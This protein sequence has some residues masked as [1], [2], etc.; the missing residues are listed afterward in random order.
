MQDCTKLD[1]ITVVGT[2]TDEHGQ[3][4]KRYLK[5][6]TAFLYTKE[7]K[8]DGVS[9]ELDAMPFSRKLRLLLPNKQ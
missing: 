6:G 1:V 3:E 4:K 7:S 2:Y 5:V 9:I 8:F